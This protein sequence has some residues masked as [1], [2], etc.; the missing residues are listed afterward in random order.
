MLLELINALLIEPGQK[1]MCV[2]VEN[3]HACIQ[4]IIGS[5]FSS[6]HP[7]KDNMV[8][9]F[10]KP[11]FDNQEPNRVILKEYPDLSIVERVFG[12]MMLCAAKDPDRIKDDGAFC[13]MKVDQYLMYAYRFGIPDEVGTDPK[14]GKHYWTVQYRELNFNNPESEE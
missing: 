6:V 10:A 14:T 2:L 1:P 7:W 8:A 11:S 12:T 3:T 13:S 5:D 4:G 9:I